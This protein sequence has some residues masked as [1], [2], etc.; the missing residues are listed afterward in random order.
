[1]DGAAKRFRRADVPLDEE[2][3]P[4][5]SRRG[6]TSLLNDQVLQRENQYLFELSL[7]QY[8]AV[9]NNL[10]LKDL[11]GKFNLTTIPVL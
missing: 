1:M 8:C 10:T 2:R 6:T 5:R 11:E 9:Q 3:I 4:C 7:K